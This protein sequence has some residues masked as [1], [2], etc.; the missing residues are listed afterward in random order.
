MKSFF[1]AVAL[2]SFFFVLHSFAEEIDL[3]TKIGK[4]VYLDFWASWC[5]PCK[6]SFPWMNELQKKYTAQGLEVITINLDS[7][8]KLADAFLKEHPATFKVVFD[9]KSVNVE[10]FKVQ[11]MPSSFI[12]NRKGEIIKSTQGFDNAEAVQIE[13][14]IVQALKE[15]P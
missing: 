15:S 8:K 10:K 3:K 11:G 12:Y 9:P 1:K 4:V 14:T 5:E 13:N 7:D 6:K 2:L